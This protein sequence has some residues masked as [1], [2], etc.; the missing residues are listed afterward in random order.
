MNEGVD[1]SR[2]VLLIL[3]RLFSSSFFSYEEIKGFEQQI[4]RVKDRDSF[5]MIL[6]GNKCDL[7][8]ERQVAVTEGKATSKALCNGAGVSH[9]CLLA[10]V[11]L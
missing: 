5:P 8:S 4:L 3:R 6:L 10:R 2:C 9:C 11:Y 7:E 1:G